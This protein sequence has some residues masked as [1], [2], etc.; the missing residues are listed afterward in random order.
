M[1]YYSLLD[2]SD[3][4]PDEVSCLKEK[5]SGHFLYSSA[6]KS[7]ESICAKAVLCCLLKEKFNLTDFTVECERNGKPKL[8][9]SPLSFNLSHSKNYVLCACGD[10]NVGCDT[11]LIK[12]FKLN[13][14]KRYFTEREYMYLAQSN[15]ETDFTKLWTL[16]ESILKLSGEG[17]SGGLAKYD[18]SDY[19]YLD[20]FEAF[21]CHFESKKIGDFIFS[22]CSQ[23]KEFSFVEFEKTLFK[24]ERE[25]L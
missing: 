1:I 15:S 14:A 16:K 3:L 24:M 5:I 2:I 19:L 13:V 21:G 20:S 12:P 9:S 7:K 10:E 8:V 25:K 22:I 18:F 23:S 11:E 17:L 4:Q 6:L